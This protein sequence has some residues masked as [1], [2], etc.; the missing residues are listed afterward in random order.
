VLWG[1]RLLAD[2]RRSEALPARTASAASAN[3]D[4]TV[5]IW[6]T[7]THVPLA[8]LHWN[9]WLLRITVYLLL[10]VLTCFFS[11]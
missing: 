6:D 8:A 4:G 9:T 11:N 3:W 2:H 5:H 1:C 7:T 10:A